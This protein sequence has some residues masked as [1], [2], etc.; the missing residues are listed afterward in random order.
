MGKYVI[1]KS[2]HVFLNFELAID[3]RQTK[4]LYLIINRAREET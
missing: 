2:N 3:L 4:L 1:K